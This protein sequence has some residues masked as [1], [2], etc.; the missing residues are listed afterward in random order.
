MSKDRNYYS[1]IVESFYPAS[2]SGKNGP[3][4]IRPASSQQFSQDLFVECSRKLV[5][6]YPVG[7]KFRFKAKLTDMQGT[8]FLYS[9]YGWPYEVVERP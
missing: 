4:H 3:V 5:E 1:I 8:P 7:T 2:T 9:Y 6:N